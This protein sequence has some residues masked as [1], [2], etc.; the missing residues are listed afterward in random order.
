MIFMGLNPPGHLGVTFLC[1]SLFL[2]LIFL[3]VCEEFTKGG[4]GLNVSQ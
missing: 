2:V 3:Y 1:I 4:Q